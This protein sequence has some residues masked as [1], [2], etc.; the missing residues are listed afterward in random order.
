MLVPAVAE[1]LARADLAR[2]SDVRSLRDVDVRADRRHV[3]VEVR[4]EVELSLLRLFDDTPLSVRVRA[5][6]VA[7]RSS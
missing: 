6:A 7:G 5:T 2:Q 3:E 4:G 1:Q